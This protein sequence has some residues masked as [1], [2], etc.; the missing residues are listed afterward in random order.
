M[1]EERFQTLQCC[2]TKGGEEMSEQMSLRINTK[3]WQIYGNT[4]GSNISQI[5]ATADWYS[6]TK[7]ERFAWAETQKIE[8]TGIAAE[9]KTV[10]PLAWSVQ[11]M[12]M[13]DGFCWGEFQGSMGYNGEVPDATGGMP[14]YCEVHDFWT[15]RPFTDKN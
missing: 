1:E 15:T 5:Q 14:W 9:R 6:W 10:F 3:G 12:T 2:S 11:E 8:L 13:P 4:G 7:N